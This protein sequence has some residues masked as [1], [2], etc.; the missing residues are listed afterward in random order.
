MF[1]LLCTFCISLFR[2]L[3]VVNKDFCMVNVGDRN[4]EQATVWLAGGNRAA[5]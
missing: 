5:D 2:L 4:V 1:L 3:P